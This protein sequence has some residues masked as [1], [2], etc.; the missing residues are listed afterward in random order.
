MKTEKKLKLWNGRGWGGRRYDADGN[1]IDDPTGK[2]YCDHL[3]VCA[4]S[5]THAIRLVNQASGH[6]TVN[7]HEAK[8]YWSEGCWG[9]TMEGI[10]PEVGVWTTQGYHDKPKRIL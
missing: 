3:Y 8:N 6:E 10:T 9:N 2:Q 7:Q 1:Y 4:Y 5:R